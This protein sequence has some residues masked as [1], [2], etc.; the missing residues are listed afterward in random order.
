MGKDIEVSS[1]AILKLKMIEELDTDDVDVFINST[2]IDTKDFESFIRSHYGNDERVFSILEELESVNNNV[3]KEL[4]H[5]PTSIIDSK[6]KTEEL[7]NIVE[8][9]K[10]SIDNLKTI[11]K[12]LEEENKQLKSYRADRV[13]TS[14]PR[15]DSTSSQILNPK[16][17]LASKNFAVQF[18]SEIGN[19]T[20]FISS[21]IVSIKLHI[22]PLISIAE[23]YSRLDNGKADLHEVLSNIMKLKEKNE[24]DHLAEYFFELVNDVTYG[25]KRILETLKSAQELSSLEEKE[26]KTTHVKINDIMDALLQILGIG[27]KHK[28]KVI[29]EYDD[30]IPDILCY[31][32]LLNQALFEILKNSVQAISIDQENPEISIYTEGRENDILICIKDNGSGIP[33]RLQD[34]I[35]EPYFTTKSGS[36]TSRGLGLN[37]T[38]YIIVEKHHGTVELYSEIG[39]G[40]EVRIVIP[41]SINYSES[42]KKTETIKTRKQ[43]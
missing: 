25:A 5:A 33:T 38:S 27:T 39:K 32:R 36:T 21:S 16:N 12:S 6:S 7:Q 30:K 41:K 4:P 11:N 15:L 2:G 42:Q 22:E 40:T 31:P 26:V 10:L 9:L 8:E 19:S 3:D 18:L 28:V 17:P 34:W 14:K 43:T 13:V 29:R 35:W 23:E 37:K 1:Q 20:R 24:Y